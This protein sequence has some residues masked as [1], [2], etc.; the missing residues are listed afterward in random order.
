MWSLFCECQYVIVAKRPKPKLNSAFGGP[1]S[2]GI[3]PRPLQII[4]ISS[5]QLK[6]VDVVEV[7]L[8]DFL[9]AAGEVFIGRPAEVAL[10]LGGID[11]IAVVVA[12]TIGHEGNQIAVRR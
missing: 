1:E 5:H 2:L 11:R 9:E 3:Y 8:H 6:P 7:P 4:C 12:G 10:D